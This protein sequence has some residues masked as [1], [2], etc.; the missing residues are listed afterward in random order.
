MKGNYTYYAISTQGYEWEG[1]YNIKG[2]GWKRVIL[3]IDQGKKK[4]INHQLFYKNLE[5]K[6]KAPN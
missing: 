1:T 3:E 4:L 6:N 2:G 5:I